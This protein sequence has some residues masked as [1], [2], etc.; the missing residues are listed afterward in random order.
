MRMA[1]VPAHLGG[2]SVA[3][4]RLGPLLCILLTAGCAGIQRAP[5]PEAP[6][7]AVAPAAVIVSKE[8]QAA[9][10][11]PPAE[12]VPAKPPIAQP[13]TWWSRG[14]PNHR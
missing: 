2:P 11:A 9:P 4:L 7:V 5:Q 8:P 6:P 3:T 13:P 14:S 1:L 12:P 10:A